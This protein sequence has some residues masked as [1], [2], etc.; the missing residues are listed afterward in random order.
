MVF[1]T[2]AV[3]II[4]EAV[5]ERMRF[6]PYLIYSFFVCGIIY[7]IYGHWM[8]GTVIFVESKLKIDDPLGAVAV[9]G[10]NGI[11]GC[12]HL[13]SLQMERTEE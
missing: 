6:A 11:W 8:W 9:H 7:P 10:A 13:E 4:A 3:T 2:K 5:A 12:L 1:C